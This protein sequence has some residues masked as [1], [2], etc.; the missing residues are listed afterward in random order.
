[1]SALLIRN[2]YEKYHFRWYKKNMRQ[3]RLIIEKKWIMCTEKRENE[4]EM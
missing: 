4:K 2:L 3:V 1:M